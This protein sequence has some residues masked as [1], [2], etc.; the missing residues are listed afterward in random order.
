MVQPGFLPL[1]T[2]AVPKPRRWASRQPKPAPKVF[3]LWTPGSLALAMTL[4]RP[5]RQ[6]GKESEGEENAASR[7]G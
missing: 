5:F 3:G 4:S 2:V 6:R 1:G 7:G